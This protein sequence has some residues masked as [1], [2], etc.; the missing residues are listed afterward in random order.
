[1]ANE[2]IAMK[3]V[4]DAKKAKFAEEWRLAKEELDQ[5]NTLI[6]ESRTAIAA[7]PK[8]STYETEKEKIKSDLRRAVDEIIRGPME[9]RETDDKGLV[10]PVA[11][12]GTTNQGCNQRHWLA[13]QPEVA[14]ILAKIRREVPN[15]ALGD[16]SGSQIMYLERLCSHLTKKCDN[17]DRASSSAIYVLKNSKLCSCDYRSPP[18]HAIK[19]CLLSHEGKMECKKQ[20]LESELHNLHKEHFS[21]QREVQNVDMAMVANLRSVRDYA[22]ASGVCQCMDNSNQFALWE[23]NYSSY[24]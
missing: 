20:K 15:H 11:Y 12:S 9:V 22:G 18:I 7:L 19:S 21:A 4:V 3:K 13:Q 23:T 1:M 5:V 17:L 6:Q 2:L 14:V 24:P 16:H 10:V 8:A